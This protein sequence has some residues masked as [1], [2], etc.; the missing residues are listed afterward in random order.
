M[1]TIKMLL[2]AVLTIISIGAMA[3][4]KAGK[5]D[6]TA[7]TSYY[8]C[9]K[10]NTVA[11]QQPGNCPICGMKLNFTKKEE[12][13]LLNAKNYVCPTHPNELSD[14]PGKCSVCGSAL[15]LSPKE[16]AHL[17]YACPMHPNEKSD[18]SGK[19]PNCG[20]AL[21]PVKKG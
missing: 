2:M 8:T 16:K 19:C 10:H 20:M 21:I 15:N 5:K 4:T 3:Q 6:T 17:G 7:H 18:K 1:K 12:A 13:H 9:P 14:K 11:M